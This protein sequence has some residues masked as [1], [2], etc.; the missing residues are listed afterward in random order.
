MT[1]EWLP[2]PDLR[3]FIMPYIDGILVH[4]KKAGTEYCSWVY[5]KG[6]VLSNGCR[7]ECNWNDGKKLLGSPTPPRTYWPTQ[8][9][10]MQKWEELYENT[11]GVEF[12]KHNTNIFT[13][14]WD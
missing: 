14:D 7:Y 9:I 10:A 5:D 4:D 11:Y 2:D 13:K 8:E 6:T 12:D 3:A 1:I